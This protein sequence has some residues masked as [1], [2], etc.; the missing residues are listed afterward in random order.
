MR[1]HEAIIDLI[2]H[3][4]SKGEE[5]YN[6]VDSG[7]AFDKV[8]R[9]Y[10]QFNFKGEKVYRSLTRG[11]RYYRYS[12]AAWRKRG[13]K[14]Q[15]YYEHLR[16]V[17]LIKEELKTCDGKK[18]SI[19]SILDKTEIAVLTR[20]EAMHIDSFHRDSMPEDGRSRLEVAGIEIAEET[21]GNSIYKEPRNMA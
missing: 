15:L 14:K 19:R 5:Y 8:V 12:E 20:K 6:L 18:E 4:L 11:P 9:N 16:P 17:K 1:Y 3:V 13:D 10:H 21:E 7:N 2:H